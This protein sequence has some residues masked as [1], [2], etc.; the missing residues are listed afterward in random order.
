M[1]E[2]NLF[3]KKSLDKISSPDQLNDYIMV[4]TPGV[5]M[6]LLSVIIALAG[7]M[8]WGVFG[9]LDTRIKVPSIVKEGKAVIYVEAEKISKVRP[10]QRVEIDENEGKVVSVGFESGIAEDVLGDLSITEAGYDEKE[11]VYEVLADIDVPNGIYMSE[12]VIDSVSPLSFLT[13]DV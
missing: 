1:S 3:R 13:G 5:W 2:N 9:R 8:V 11:I 4:M 12:I 6:I 7:A 10:G